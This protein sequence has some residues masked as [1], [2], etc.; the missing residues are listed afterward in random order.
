[1]PIGQVPIL[2]SVTAPI[3]LGAIEASSIASLTIDQQNSIV[4]GTIVV[5]PT[6]TYVYNGYGNKTLEASYT[7]II[8]TSGGYVT[9]AEFAAANL[10]H[11]NENGANID[12]VV[13]FTNTSNQ[14]DS[15]IGGWGFGVENSNGDYIYID[16]VE[17]GLNNGAKIKKGTT[18]AGLG[19]N[20]GIALKC[21][22]DY[23]L[24]WEAGRLFTLE[25]DGFTI[26]SVEYCTIEP[27]ATDDSA[28]GFVVGSR[29]AM[30]NGQVFV[31]QNNSVGAAV[32]SLS[33]SSVSEYATYSGGT[34]QEITSAREKNIK[35][36][37][38]SGFNTI[39]LPRGASSTPGQD[40]GARDGDIL[41]LFSSSV[42]GGSL[43]V[44][45]STYTGSNYNVVGGNYTYTTLI[46]LAQSNY[47][48]QFIFFD[49][50]WHILKSIP[51]AAHTHV[52][53]DVTNLQSSLDDK[54][55]INFNYNAS[56]F[57]ATTATTA[58]QW[59]ATIVVPGGIVGTKGRVSVR[60]WAACS[61][62]ASAK[63]IRAYVT[64]TNPGNAIGG[65]RICNYN[66]LASTLGTTAVSLMRQFTIINR[67]SQSSQIIEPSASGGESA[68]ASADTFEEISINTANTWYI[69]IGLQKD[70]TTDALLLKQVFIEGVYAA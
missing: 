59:Q 16:P 7:G 21:S 38:A 19:G 4:R 40:Q 46:T 57:S 67:G 55:K 62:S 69:V 41:R 33:L 43:A 1:M 29:W 2:P 37:N 14:T 25:Q 32:W 66:S 34:T 60:L 45:Q 18:D 10:I 39:R 15:E 3:P 50:S 36:Q 61:P 54:Q 49:G 22:I 64:S 9:D 17:I 27:T 35:F 12:K 6:Q 13:T 42:Q 53:S 52:I 65:T 68:T 51:S 44:A 11:S 48:V 23:E 47:D 58:D 26:R 30:I 70:S 5:T 28:K 8:S 20:K 56:T 31:C 63:R 24:K